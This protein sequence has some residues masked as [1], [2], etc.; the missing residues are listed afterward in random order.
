MPSTMQWWVLATI[1]QRPSSRPS[2]IHISQGSTTVERLHHHLRHEL[3][4]SERSLRHERYPAQVVV[5]VEATSSIHSGLVRFRRVSRARWR[6]R[7]GRAGASSRRTPAP[8]HRSVPDLRRRRPIRCSS[9]STRCR[10]SGR[11]HPDCPFAPSVPSIAN[12]A[13]VPA[14][15][16]PRSFGTVAAN[17]AD[18]DVGLHGN[19]RACHRRSVWGGARWLTMERDL[20]GEGR[21]PS[22]AESRGDSDGCQDA[23]GTVSV[24]LNWADARWDEPLRL[25]V[26][27]WCPSLLLA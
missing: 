23:D 6:Q 18:H 3:L 17:R 11:R 7:A 27:L 1:A 9:G 12:A 4:Q 14:S 16:A 15:L 22:S 20:G 10:C 25:D 13:S 26:R 5:E 24:A 8:L 19:A 21:W 2:T